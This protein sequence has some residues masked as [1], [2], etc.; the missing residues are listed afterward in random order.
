MVGSTKPRFRNPAEKS[1][2][3]PEHGAEKACPALA[4]GWV[5]VFGLVAVRSS[6]RI[7]SGSP[8]AI[9]LI[10]VNIRRDGR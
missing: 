6:N 4:G 3:T 8:E 5:L 1:A 2:R 10:C 9:D 7:T